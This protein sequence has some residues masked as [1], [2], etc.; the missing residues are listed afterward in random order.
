MDPIV[1][2][3]QVPENEIIAEQ[4]G[5]GNILLEAVIV[6]VD[7]QLVTTLENTRDTLAEANT[8]S[9]ELSQSI[10]DAELL[11][12]EISTDLII[13]QND[14]AS[15]RDEIVDAASDV[16]TGLATKA[17]LTANNTL[18]GTT[19]FAKNVIVD[20]PQNDSA[21]WLYRNGVPGASI[22]TLPG[23][24]GIRQA[25]ATG[26]T[27]NELRLYDTYARFG[28][29]VLSL[30]PV[31]NA[32]SNSQLTDKAYVDS[33]ISQAVGELESDLSTAASTD[34]TFTGNKT[35]SGHV[36]IK[37]NAFV[38]GT[39][40]AVSSNDVM[41]GDRIITLNSELTG[42]PTLDA[43]IEIE[44]G[45]YTNVMLL[46]DESE[47][48]WVGG[49]N[50][51]LSPLVLA[52]Q[53]S[54]VV[55][56]W[57]GDERYVKVDG[58]STLSRGLK[59]VSNDDAE[60]D[61][62]SNNSNLNPAYVLSTESDSHAA[63]FTYDRQAKTASIE[64][65]ANGTVNGGSMMTFGAN[66]ITAHAPVKMT[67][68][69]RESDS[70]FALTTKSYVDDGFVSLGDVNQ[71]VGGEM[72]F[73][74][75]TN[76]H[77]L[78]VKP[79]TGSAAIDWYYNNTLSGKVVG[80]D[81]RLDLQRVKADGTLGASLQLLDS[82]IY[83]PSTITFDGQ[84]DIH[85]QFT[86]KYDNAYLTIDGTN[87]TSPHF[88]MMRESVPSFRIH[89]HANYTEFQRYDSAGTL[90][91]NLRMFNSYSIAS[92]PIRG[93]DDSDA[94]SF[95]TKGYVDGNFVDKSSNETIAG[96]KTYTG[97][98]RFLDNPILYKTDPY[99]TLDGR[100]GSA[101]HIQLLRNGMASFRIHG[102][103]AN[104]EIQ[105]CGS[106]GTI[107]LRVKI[108][109]NHFEV[110]NEIIAKEGSL[111]SDVSSGNP[112]LL[113]SRAGT[114]T[115]GLF[116]VA[117]YS[118]LRRYD[119]NGNSANEILI[120]DTYTQFQKSIEVPNGTFSQP[121]LSFDNGCGLMGISSGSRLDIKVGGKN[122]FKFER[123]GNCTFT[124][125]GGDY[126]GGRVRLYEGES[127]GSNYVQLQSASAMG[128]NYTMVMPDAP[129]TVGQ[130]L[131]ILSVSGTSLIMGWV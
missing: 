48:A 33:R 131:Q 12:A 10:S 75:T 110:D 56:E 61:L 122:A 57:Q 66:A 117:N 126:T 63:A 7:A 37:G 29:P 83:T 62:K 74:G 119:A 32:S 89:S 15:V 58:T 41:I 96:N 26:V 108:F 30:S 64:L 106:D 100:E 54:D 50:G 22:M 127:N 19:T 1:T 71:T 128:S 24:T 102:Y 45:N 20:N 80:Y 49:K 107:K 36:T 86:L 38:E 5:Q 53:I 6:S 2:Q 114:E 97:V 67:V 72:T 129:G 99:L 85:S 90:H 92:K 13:A 91:S 25:N 87:N 95:T 73:T 60:I 81:M 43:G 4:S 14:L 98:T 94:A 42:I 105:R 109:D 121:G 40:N 103:E 69:T 124:I 59:I 79:D 82:Q 88:Q 44:R 8:R 130:Q 39:L 52:N 116:G 46:W 113:L 34:Q 23:Y 70:A 78:N 17:S 47:D 123:G 9:A 104:T 35:F 16:H 84:V 112:A 31:N 28:S 68:P 115:F 3:F 51:A 111:I 55:R 120:Q 21:Y 125:Q 18:T 101:A 93:V 65:T 27:T 11:T 76:V 77:K 118:L